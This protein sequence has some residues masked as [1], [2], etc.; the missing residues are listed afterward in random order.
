M[1][2]GHLREGQANGLGKVT[3]SR[4]LGKEGAG[5]DHPRAGKW[6]KE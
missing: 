2:A 1:R 4:T 3:V 6:R 5:E